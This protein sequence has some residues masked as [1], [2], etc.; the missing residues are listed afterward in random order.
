M[1]CLNDIYDLLEEVIELGEDVDYEEF[2]VNV[3]DDHRY[4]YSK[5]SEVFNKKHKKL[6]KLMKKY[7]KVQ[8]DCSAN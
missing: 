1:V 6:V 3:C 2:R 7:L 5:T 4:D 8:G